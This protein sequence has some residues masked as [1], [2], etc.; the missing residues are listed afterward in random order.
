MKVFEFAVFF[1]GERCMR[2]S[3]LSQCRDLRMD[4][5][6]VEARG[7]INSLSCRVENKL[8]AIELT[9]RKIEKERVA[10]VDLGMRE[11]VMVREVEWSRVCQIRRRS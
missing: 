9:A 7:F 10:V 2:S 8:K 3:I 11:V 4:E 6:M 5:V 1:V